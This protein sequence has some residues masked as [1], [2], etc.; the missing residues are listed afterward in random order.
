[1]QVIRLSHSG[2]AAYENGLPFMSAIVFG[3]P[4][5]P[6]FFAEPQAVMPIRSATPNE[7]ANAAFAARRMCFRTISSLLLVALSNPC[8]VL[9]P[10]TL[11]ARS[12]PAKGCALPEREHAGGDE[13]EGRD[14]E[15]R[16]EDAR[17]AVGRLVG[18]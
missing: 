15:R 17:Q 10:G 5:T 16:C 1:M 7:T 8:L 3:A 12:H 18:H 11:S 13:R 4:A 2:R 9:S 6:L 14:A